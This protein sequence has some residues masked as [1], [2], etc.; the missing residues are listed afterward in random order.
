MDSISENSLDRPRGLLFGLLANCIF[1]AEASESCP[2][3]EIRNS[4]SIEEK[5]RYVMGLSDAEV[6][7]I[8]VQHEECYE[9]RL[10]NLNQW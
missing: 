6:K 1:F 5:H 2:L 3:S 4:F 9:K 10:S 8:L 7:S